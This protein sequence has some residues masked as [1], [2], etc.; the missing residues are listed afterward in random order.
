M[1]FMGILEGTPRIRTHRIDNIGVIDRVVHRHSWDNTSY[2]LSVI[3]GS[4][5]LQSIGNL[6][7]HN[8]AT[9]STILGHSSCG[10]SAI[11]GSYIVWFI[12]IL[13]VTHCTVSIIQAPYIVIIGIHGVKNRMVYR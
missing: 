13:V 5:L 3:L 11:L 10:V 7:C 12:G 2:D 8:S 9:S 1:W 4:F 6:E